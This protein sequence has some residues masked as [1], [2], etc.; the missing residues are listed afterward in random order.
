MSGN[1]YWRNWLIPLQLN[2][3]G[4][5]FLLVKNSL[6][7]LNFTK[8]DSLTPCRL[9]CDEELAQVVIPFGSRVSISS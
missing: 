4:N 5:Q 9:N 8:T 2:E 3:F 6:M 1:G 7:S